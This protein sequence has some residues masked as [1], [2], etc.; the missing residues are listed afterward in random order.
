MLGRGGGKGAR[1]GATAR[2]GEKKKTH[3]DRPSSRL[4]SCERRRKG[5]SDRPNNIYGSIQNTLAVAAAAQY[6]VT[7]LAATELA[8]SI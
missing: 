8:Y 6:M 3:D 5:L 2:K 1:D 7:V 4:A